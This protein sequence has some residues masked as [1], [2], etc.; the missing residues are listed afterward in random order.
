MLKIQN[1]LYLAGV[2]LLVSLPAMGSLIYYRLTGDPT[3]R[4]LGIT[5]SS[6]TE[7]LVGGTSGGITVQINWGD[8]ANPPNSRQQVRQVLEKALSVYTVDFSLRF[9]DTGGDS[10]QIYFVT[11]NSRLGPY[12]LNNISSGIPAALAAYNIANRP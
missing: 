1:A 9:Q 3:F 10:I 5:I 7:R 6:L 4:P 8:N 12:R 11:D 2:I